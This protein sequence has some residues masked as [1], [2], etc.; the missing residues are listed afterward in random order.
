MNRPQ[1]IQRIIAAALLAASAGLALSSCAGQRQLP[2][3]APEQI[4]KVQ[5]AEQRAAYLDLAERRAQLDRS[6]VP[7]Q[8]ALYFDQAERRAGVGGPAD[9]GPYLDQA[10]RRLTL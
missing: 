10:E 2:E 5:I 9:V 4:S 1:K 8:G 7:D 6:V 3:P